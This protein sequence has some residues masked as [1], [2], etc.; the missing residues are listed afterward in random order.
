MNY[1]IQPFGIRYSRAINRFFLILHLGL[2]LFALP[3]VNVLIQWFIDSRPARISISEQAAAVAGVFFLGWVFLGFLPVVVLMIANRG[4]SRARR[5]GQVL[6]AFV[7][8][9]GLLNF[10]VGTALYLPCLY[11]ILFDRDTQSAFGGEYPASARNSLPLSLLFWCLFL[12]WMHAFFA[13]FIAGG[14][15]SPGIFFRNLYPSPALNIAFFLISVVTVVCSLAV[16]FRKDWARRTLQWALAA[17]IAA[18]IAHLFY[19]AEFF[20]QID[21]VGWITTAVESFKIADPAKSNLLSLLSTAKSFLP[22]SGVIVF[23]FHHLWLAAVWEGWLIF[24]L[25]QPRVLNYTGWDPGDF[26]QRHR[27]VFFLFVVATFVIFTAAGRFLVVT[28]EPRQAETAQAGPEEQVAVPAAKEDA[29][30]AV[31]AA[32]R[33]AEPD[34]PVRIYLIEHESMDGVYR[35]NKEKTKAIQALIHEDLSEVRKNRQNQITYWAELGVPSGFSATLKYANVLFA[36]LD[37][38]FRY[39]AGLSLQAVVEPATVMPQVRDR[40]MTYLG[41]LY[42]E[43][44]EK[45]A[46]KDILDLMPEG[47]MN[48]DVIRRLMKDF[49]GIEI[50]TE[51][52]PFESWVSLICSM[53]WNQRIKEDLGRGDTE[54]ALFATYNCL[55]HM[56]KNVHE[57]DEKMAREIDAYLKK[58]PDNYQVVVRGAAHMGLAEILSRMKVP[59]KNIFQ[60]AARERSDYEDYL[61]NYAVMPGRPFGKR[62]SHDEELHVKRALLF[63]MVSEVFRL[64]AKMERASFDSGV[65]DAFTYIIK[66]TS[67]RTL[68]EWL[69]AYRGKQGQLEEIQLA[70]W[71]IV[72]DGVRDMTEEEKKRF[73][74][75]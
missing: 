68:D 42:R 2:T 65:N 16:L 52:S 33:S 75:N 31:P 43:S 41:R 56:N 64:S 54:R 30:P 74:N 73:V 37:R 28:L 61:R 20:R 72:R 27:K 1:A 3:F 36:K 35:Y 53:Y 15:L 69:G 50:A 23:L 10:P 7:A 19:L 21:P 24:Y 13:A 14:L 60:I 57:R 58:Y 4:L 29:P 40:V 32:A 12:A 38:E 51:Q 6:Q 18:G 26:R 46:G 71:R 67:H 44:A 5:W 25:A 22:S 62:F 63:L 8:L 39:P 48:G 59:S 45:D 11:F 49:R 17:G 55:A 70:A 34:V 47:T 9:L 66:H